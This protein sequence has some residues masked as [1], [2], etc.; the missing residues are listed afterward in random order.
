M[1]RSGTKDRDLVFVLQ[2]PTADKVVVALIDD[3]ASIQEFRRTAWAIV[4][5][6]RSSSPAHHPIIV[7]R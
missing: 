7:T 3:K 1:D 2:Q 4:L 6:P 5:T